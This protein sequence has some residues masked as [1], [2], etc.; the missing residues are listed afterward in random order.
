L[1]TKKI[2]SS[3]T[4]IVVYVDDIIVAGVIVI[5]NVVAIVSIKPQGEIV[6]FFKFTVNPNIDYRR[7]LSLAACTANELAN[8]KHFKN[9]LGIKNNEKEKEKPS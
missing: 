5:V 2:P 4:V 1:F 8:F 9:Q 6:I 3:F 7:N